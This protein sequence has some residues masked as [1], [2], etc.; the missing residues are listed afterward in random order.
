[1]QPTNQDL[2]SPG[3]GSWRRMPV[4]LVTALCLLAGVAQ[5]TTS[6]PVVRLF[7][8][9]VLEDIRE[10]GQ[11]AEDMENN[12]QQIIH[13]LDHC[14]LHKVPTRFAGLPTCLRAKT[15][16]L[17]GDL[18]ADTSDAPTASADDADSYGMT[19]ALKKMGELQAH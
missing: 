11:V 12:L 13:R 15:S 8:T 2:R 3:P 18:P 4:L 19:H 16:R 17:F 1:M 9:T 6:G 7:P 14:Q 10:T 5:A